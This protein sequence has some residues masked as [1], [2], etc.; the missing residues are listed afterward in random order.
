MKYYKKINEKNE[1]IALF[2][3]TSEPKRKVDLVELT[4]EEYNEIKE[5]L[6][7]SEEV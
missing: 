6:L 7:T 1:I 5:E 4:E 2:A 3:S